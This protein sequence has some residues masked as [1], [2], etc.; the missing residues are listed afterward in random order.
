MR[1]LKTGSR[2]GAQKPACLG[3]FPGIAGHLGVISAGPPGECP[4]YPLCRVQPIVFHQSRA[5]LYSPSRDDPCTAVCHSPPRPHIVSLSHYLVRLALTLSRS[6]SFSHWGTF[7]LSHQLSYGIFL[8]QHLT[9]SRFIPPTPDCVSR[10]RT[11]QRTDTEPR[12]VRRTIQRTGTTHC[13]CSKCCCAHTL[14][15]QPLLHY[16]CT[17]QHTAHHTNH[18]CTN[19][20]PYST[21][22]VT[23]TSAAPITTE[24]TVAAPTTVA[25]TTA[26]LAMLH[27]TLCIARSKHIRLLT[28]LLFPPNNTFACFP[29]LFADSDYCPCNVPLQQFHAYNSGL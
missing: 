22:L 29:L 25:P 16:C 27:H 14:L 9:P 8:C 26:A 4:S 2:W 12:T 6:I 19:T 10:D 21:P 24:P 7:A 15:C 13:C 23:P 28:F 11:I 1:T 3:R 17:I 20:A 18:C 5:P